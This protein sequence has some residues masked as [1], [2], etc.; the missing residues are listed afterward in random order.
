MPGTLS[1]ASAD[2]LEMGLF[3]EMTVQSKVNHHQHLDGAFSLNP[4]LAVRVFCHLRQ[5]DGRGEKEYLGLPTELKGIPGGS[6]KDESRMGRKAWT[7]AGKQGK[8]SIQW[9]LESRKWYQMGAWEN[10][11][12]GL[13]ASLRI[14]PNHWASC[15]TCSSPWKMMLSLGVHSQNSGSGRP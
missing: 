6:G 10:T 9:G 11:S 3:L 1:P 4:G 14:Q 12:P 13:A 5:A 15:L 2:D 7:G 8:Q